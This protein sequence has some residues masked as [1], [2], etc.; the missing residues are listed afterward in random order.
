MSR[1][2]QQVRF[3]TSQDGT[4]IAYAVCGNGPPLVMAGHSFSHLESEW[5]CL[6]RR[7][8]LEL[9]SQRHTLIRYD[10][11]GT[12]LSDR[13]CETYAFARYVEDFEAVVAASK[14]DSF[15]LIGLTGGGAIAVTHAAR[16]PKQERGMLLI[17]GY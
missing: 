10:M 7:P 3:C 2:N 17:G 1:E 5:D 16:H 14:L 12:G 4:R 6:V 13:D 9:L 15:T 8:L 11:R